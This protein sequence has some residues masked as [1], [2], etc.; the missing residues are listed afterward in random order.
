MLRIIEASEIASKKSCILFA[1]TVKAF[2]LSI[3][4]ALPIPLILYLIG[5]AYNDSYTN[6][7][8]SLSVG[9]AFIVLGGVLLPIMCFYEL[10][11]PKGVIDL[12]FA[13]PQDI[14]FE[15]RKLLVKI[16]PFI[17]VSIFVVACIEFSANE[18]WK[19]S[20]GR[21]AFIVFAIMCQYTVWRIYKGPNS[22]INKIFSQLYFGKI[23]GIQVVIKFL[24]F[25]CPVL[26]I[27]ASVSGYYYTALRFGV[28]LYLTD[29]CILFAIIAAGLANRWK[30]LTRRKLAR[31]QAQ[32]KRAL[33]K[34]Q[35]DSTST[36][37]KP[38]AED[39]L[40]DLALVDIQ[41]SRLVLG[42]TIAAILISVWFIWGNMLPALDILNKFTIGHTIESISETK[43]D[44][45][46]VEYLDTTEREVPITL[47]HLFM[48]V[49]IAMLTVV[50]TK[51][52]PGIL[53]LTI[54][55]RL[56]FA[57]GERYA[58]TSIVRYVIVGLGIALTFNAVGIGWAR[59]HWLIAALSLGL[60]FGLQEIF[61]NFVSGLI[62]LFERPIR[63]GDTVTVGGVNGTVTRIRI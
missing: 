63:I 50:A 54:L 58:I 35:Q 43:V 30:L 19:E 18:D 40:L 60:G 20:L 47:K 13:W 3:L 26:L 25:I 22:L 15:T 11:R 52:I 37:S 23:Q 6:S 1:P 49:L 9:K 62:L 27:L 8:H 14:C 24:I 28:N 46:G 17:L 10:L 59:V 51:N 29:S 42:A 45:E 56:K 61:A 39:E 34:A 32:K 16:V 31:E 38:I 55:Q 41:A 36:E 12:H 53:E 5:Y 2:A 44:T 57:A 4:I 48:S 33:L 7:T 21:L